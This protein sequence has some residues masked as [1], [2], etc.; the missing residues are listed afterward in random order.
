[1]TTMLHIAFPVKYE[2]QKEIKKEGREHNGCSGLE[3]VVEKLC[4]A[5]AFLRQPQAD[6]AQ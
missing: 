3:R 5:G 2:A 4:A 6:G 1:M